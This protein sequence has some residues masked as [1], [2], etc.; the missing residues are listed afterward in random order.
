MMLILL[1]PRYRALK[2]QLNRFAPGDRLKTAVL[3]LLGL[4]FWA[5]LFGVSYRVLSYF[6][7]IE[8]L[9][10][11]LA[12]RL[13]S[14]VLLTFFSILLFSNVVT[15]LSTYYLSD[16]LDL[17]LSA[18]VRIEHI[19]RAKFIETIA[20][21]S[22]MTLIYGLPVFLAYGAVFRATLLY[23]LGLILTIIPF[24]VIPAGI[25][26]IVTMLLVNAFPARRAKDVLVLLGLLFF[27]VMYVLFRML[28]PEKLVDPDAFPTLVQYLTAM[29]GPVSP[30]LPSSWASEA[31]SPLLRRTMDGSLFSLLMLWSTAGAVVVVGEWVCDRIYYAGWSR[32]QEGKKATLS[33]SR[34][35]NAFS[36]LAVLPFRGKMRAI[37][38]KDVKLFFRDTS[39]WSQLFL[40]L[41]LMVVYIYSF[42]LL[43]LDRAAMPSFYLQNLIS[44]LNLGMVG[45]VTTAVAVRFVFPAVSL[46]GASFWI[47]R[48]APLSIGDFLWAKF[49]SSLLPL[50]VLS[51]ILIV[52]SNV[53]LK[54]TPFM[55]G[56]G[57]VT[58][59]IMTFGI[60]SLGVGLGAAFPKFKHEN[61][62]QIPTGFGGIVYMLVTM[63]FI[64]TVV[65]LEAWPVYRI[66]TSQMFG[67]R[68]PA[69]GW[70][71]I[72]CSFLLVL[73]VNLLVLLL[74]MR[75]G[76]K[77]LREREV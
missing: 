32:S 31:L 26:I 51:E 49:W 62:A 50:L 17:L 24:L 10:D 4:A 57:I 7:T 21:S 28:R 69:S 42:K 15:S 38:L 11:L 65:V 23:Y 39:Q 47:I 34:A 72:G 25:G 2:N 18:P 12:L 35:A 14:M 44:F 33:R 54:A 5:F 29:R 67:G 75:A 43:P 64:G 6:R 46:E 41:A 13:L 40:L 58:V 53:L 16:E 48:S 73:A 66:F 45:F 27:V 20:D 3:T 56:L 36:R 52:L 22:W 37:V 70:L 77:R 76:L 74:P 19:Y 59:F 63:L 61:V 30:L 55:M 71:W 9:G 8:G 1:T 68:I 60:T